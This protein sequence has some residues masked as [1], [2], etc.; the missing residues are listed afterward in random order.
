MSGSFSIPLKGLKDGRHT[1]KFEINKEFFDLFDESEIK[2]GD[3]NAIAEINKMSAHLDLYISISGKV[4]ISCDRC[5]EMF[6]YGI[7]TENRLLVKAGRV[8]DDSDPEII[9]IPSP[10]HELDLKQYLYEFIHLALPIQRVHPGDDQ[11]N[12]TCDPVMLRKLDEYL[13]K[14]EESE[15]HHQWEE[16]K[17]LME[18]N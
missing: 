11:G 2:E 17:K 3:L 1:F 9:T 7:H 6:Y 15:N 14:S 13:V 5:L 8:F 4:R 18:N 16:L 12:V 10:D